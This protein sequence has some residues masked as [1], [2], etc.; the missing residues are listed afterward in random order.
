MPQTPNIHHSQFD[1]VYLNHV[2]LVS[3]AADLRHIP[4]LLLDQRRLKSHQHEQCE[5]AVVP[6]LVQ[7][8]QPY[9]KHLMD[10]RCSVAFQRYRRHYEVN[11]F[12]INIRKCKI[13]FTL[14]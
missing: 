5:N 6:I 8:P 10:G 4:H 3:H 9:T 1:Q 11:N 7:A 12:I 13:V 2:G 14:T